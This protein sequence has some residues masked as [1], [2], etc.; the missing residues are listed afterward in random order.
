MTS[1]WMLWLTFSWTANV[2]DLWGFL[3][4]AWTGWFRR[5]VFDLFVTLLFFKG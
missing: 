5:T 2:F 4:G 1:S 3:F